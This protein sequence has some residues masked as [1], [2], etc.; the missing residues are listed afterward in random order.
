MAGI[1]QNDPKGFLTYDNAGNV[2]GGTFAQEDFRGGIRTTGN[3]DFNQWWSYGWDATFLTDR[4]FTRNYNVLSTAQVEITSD[5]F[6]TGLH[7]RNYFDARAE[8]FQ[9]LAD[10]TDPKYSQERQAVIAPILDHNYIF[11]NPILGGEL[12]MNSNLVAFTRNEADPFTVGGQT[13]YHGL[14]GDF[15]RASY[16]VDWQRKMIGPLGQVFTPFAS[17]RADVFSIDASTPP[18]ELT[19]RVHT[20]PPDADA[21]PGVDLADPHHG[22]RIRAM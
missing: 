4:T 7:D 1:F 12:S 14:S 17:V 3:F 2:V 18:A 6:L 11:S 5:V 21:R 15:A 8:E 9:I 16:D 19:N 22:R 10:K 13:F 20:D